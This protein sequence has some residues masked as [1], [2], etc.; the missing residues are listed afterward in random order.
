MHFFP[1]GY[2]NCA[3][4]FPIYI[5]DDR[6]DEDAFKVLE[7]DI[8]LLKKSI[9]KIFILHITWIYLILILLCLIQIRY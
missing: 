5:G 9:V 6:S 3:D 7:L 4:V 2:A 1:T 8:E